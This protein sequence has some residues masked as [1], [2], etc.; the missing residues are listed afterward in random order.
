MRRE[1]LPK[2]KLCTMISKN[3]KANRL[4]SSFE[5]NKAFSK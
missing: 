3:N 5:I 4:F 2:V 1:L